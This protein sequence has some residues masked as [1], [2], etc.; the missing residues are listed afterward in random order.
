MNQMAM[1]PSG[2]SGGHIFREAAL[3]D[4]H[5][6]LAK[7]KTYLASLGSAAVAFSGG[8]DSTFLLRIAYDTLG[9]N[10]VAVTARSCSFPERELKEASDYARSQGIAH[11]IF[12][13]EELLIK[14]FCE[15]PVD[16]CYLCKKEL[17]AKINKIKEKHGL[18]Y[19]IEG[20]NMDDMNDHRPGL[21]AAEEF[22]VRSP[23][24]FS[25]MTKNDIRMLSK[26]I[27]L[28]TWN[29]QS[30]ACLS[31]RFVYGETIT[32]EKLKMVEYSEQLL[33]DLGFHN[34]RVRIHG[35][36]AR[37]ETA[38][39]D[40]EKFLIPSVRDSVYAK[41]KEYGF[42]YITLDLLGYRTGSMNEDLY[43]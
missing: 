13:S 19:M 12:E 39:E 26:E 27:G 37:I 31:S 8:V 5:L 15:N 20:S 42:C 9:S 21:K 11:I 4:R 29:K 3:D 7:L 33:L 40:H 18:K 36:L 2:M 35:N 41:F 25:E 28:A 6:K 30:F 16:R 23:L 17:F 34:V 22:D 43:R 38:R 10:A 1:M 14:G 24:R 32:A